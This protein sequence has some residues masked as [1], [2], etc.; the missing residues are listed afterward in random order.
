MRSSSFFSQRALGLLLA[1][2]GPTLSAAQETSPP[3]AAPAA[4][5]AEE[6]SSAGTFSGNVALTSEYYFRGITQTGAAPTLQGGFDY[7]VSLASP[8]A[9]YLGVWGSNVDFNEG[10]DV[11]GATIEIDWYGGLKGNFGESRTSWDVGFIYYAYPG[12]AA[13]LDDYDFLDFQSAL[14]HDFGAAAV[15]ASVN[16]SQD[17]FGASGTGV[18][19]KLTL[20]VPIPSVK[21]MA[22]SGYLAKQFIEKEAVFG[23]PDYVEWNVSATLSALGFDL[24]IAYSDTDIPNRKS[25]FVFSAARSF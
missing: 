19:P 9:L 17:N 8:V 7:E 2:F 4:A 23:A 16:Y 6:E 24:S 14:G 13:S 25:A 22:L 12:D 15:T 11:D 21:G 3:P 10:G 5:T 20:D 1:A 18:Y